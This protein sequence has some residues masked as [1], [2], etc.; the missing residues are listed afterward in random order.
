MI[1]NNDLTHNRWKISRQGYLPILLL[2]S[3]GVVITSAL[4]Q[5]LSRL[6]GERVQTAFNAAARDRILVVQ[7]ELQSS[8]NVVQDIGSFFAANRRVARGQYREFVQP[9]LQRDPSI[10]SLEWVP[11]VK[12]DQRTAFVRDARSDFPSFDI[13]AR[14]DKESGRSTKNVYYP[15]LYA[16]PYQRGKTLLGLDLATVPTE[17]SAI[18]RART[19]R[20]MQITHNRVSSSESSV[21]VVLNVYLPV[22]EN[23][24]GNVDR[25]HVDGEEE[26]RGAVGGKKSKRLRGMAVGRFWIEAIVK[27]A[28]ANLSPSGIDVTIRTVE[29]ETGVNTP[30]DALYVHRSRLRGAVWFARNDGPTETRTLTDTIDVAGNE[31]TIVCTAVPGI[32]EVGAWAV[33]F[34]F[35]GGVAFTL[36]LAA[37]VI[38]LIGRAEQV[39]RLVSQ[40]TLELQHSNQALNRQV[41][42]R[43]KVENALQALNVT[44]E[45]RVAL[46]TEEA[47]RRARE[48]EQFAYVTSHDLKAPLRAIANLAGWLKEDMAGMLT[49]ETQEQ[50]DLMRDRVGRMHSLIEGLLTYSRVGRTQGELEQVDS[51]ALVAEV[52][53]SIAPPPGFHIEIATDLPN[54]CTDRLQLSQVFANLIGNSIK[55]HYKEEGNIRVFGRDLDTHCAFAVADDGPGIP[56]QYHEKIFKMFYTLQVKDFSGDTGI[57]LALVKKIVEDHEGSISINSAPGAGTEIRFTWKRE[58]PNDTGNHSD[59]Q[60]DAPARI[61]TIEE[62]Q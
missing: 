32:F 60:G 59:L 8:L 6:E 28:L 40:R 46:R 57:G 27:R 21:A 19:E 29:N 7:R 24:R 53:D 9:V 34:V 48:L 23:P 1:G 36:L 16:H 55:H 43:L 17:F 15:V 38:S 31:W 50:L 30:A 5:Q 47:E 37:Y 49:E 58:K 62:R 2:V 20:R 61:P 25:F 45:R 56:E 13:F 42:E 39:E 11:E 10:R 41:A 33:R 14:D 26:N 35:I 12:A 18:Q 3:L 4:V 22:F 54:L 52:V 51:R 44:L